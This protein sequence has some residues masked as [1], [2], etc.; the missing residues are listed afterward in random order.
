MFGRTNYWL[1]KPK[2]NDTKG[3]VPMMGA[4]MLLGPLFF[5]LAILAETIN[6]GVKK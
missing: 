6:K 4:M 1:S 2:A 3:I 5:P